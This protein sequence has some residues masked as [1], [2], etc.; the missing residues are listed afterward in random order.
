LYDPAGW[1]TRGRPWAIEPGQRW[2]LDGLFL[3]RSHQ[4]PRRSMGLTPRQCPWLVPLTILFPQTMVNRGC[5]RSV[6]V[7]VNSTYH[8]NAVGGGCPCH[9]HPR[10]GKESAHCCYPLQARSAFPVLPIVRE[11][12]HLPSPPE[13]APTIITHNWEEKSTILEHGRGGHRGPRP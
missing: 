7:V 9:R 3:G 11:G 6:A 12:E 2:G 13:E 1:S 5:P 10:E 4:I 8:P